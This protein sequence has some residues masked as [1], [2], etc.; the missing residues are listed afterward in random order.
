MVIMQ[1]SNNIELPYRTGVGIM[2]I[3]NQKQVFVGKRVDKQNAWQMPQGG[4]DNDET[5]KEAAMRELLEEIGTNKV[6]FIS[7]SKEWFYYNVPK[8][9][10][11]KLWNGQYRGQKQKWFLCKFLGQDSEINLNT[12]HPEFIEWR[13]VELSELPV[14][15]VPFKQKLY[16]KVIKAF[17][18]RI[19]NL[20]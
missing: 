6:R 10:I 9:L 16:C 15:I 8:R 5:P 17:Q 2:I 11:P 13:W 18:N 1:A 20:E 12:E 7:E 19:D 14:I 3:N 4:V